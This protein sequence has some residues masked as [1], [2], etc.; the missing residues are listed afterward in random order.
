M[1]SKL[2]SVL[3]IVLQEKNCLLLWP[4][5]GSSSLQLI[6]CLDVSIRIGDLSSFQE[7]QKDHPF[8]IL[9]DTQCTSLYPLKAVIWN[10]SSMGN[11]HVPVH[12]P[13][14]WFWLIVM[15]PCVITG[16][17]TMQE[18][19]TFS[20]MF[21]Q[22]VSTSLHIMLFLFLPEQLGDPS[23]T[24]FKI[25][26]HYHQ[27]FQCIEDDIQLLT[28]LSARNLPVQMVELIE[29]LFILSCDS[30]AWPSRPWFI[31]PIAV[32]TTETHHPPPHCDHIHCLVSISNS[33]ID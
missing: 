10:L 23:G 11:S 26:W 33:A 15:T 27:G 2:L 19:L 8:P 20:F 5:S 22:C 3:S 21:V 13:L 9:K 6:Q 1:L 14:F 17:D 28:W 4:D 30:C 29:M 25:C 7:I 24:N 31:F 32:T 16:S 12:R 18:T